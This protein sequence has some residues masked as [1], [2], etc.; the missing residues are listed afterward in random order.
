MSERKKKVLNLSNHNLIEKAKHKV[1]RAAHNSFKPTKDSQGRNIKQHFSTW[2]YYVDK[3]QGEE[4]M[5]FYISSDC[6]RLPLH[7]GIKAAKKENSTKEGRA[8]TLLNIQ[9]VGIQTKDP[10]RLEY[11]GLPLGVCE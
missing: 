11:W 4:K 1:N 7:E 2:K 3:T 6:R 10:E 9:R 8:L 5:K